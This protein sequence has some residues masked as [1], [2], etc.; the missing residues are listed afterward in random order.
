MTSQKVFPPLKRGRAS[1]TIK[2]SLMRRG[3]WMRQESSSVE[4]KRP[5]GDREDPGD[6]RP[7]H[8]RRCGNLLL[9]QRRRCPH[10]PR[11]THRLEGMKVIS[12][13]VKPWKGDNWRASD[14]C[15]LSSRKPRG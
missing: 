6:V 8:W 5:S 4:G 7:Q 3:R 2:G 14:K 11:A 9:S 13:G 10:L 12:N 15:K 1:D